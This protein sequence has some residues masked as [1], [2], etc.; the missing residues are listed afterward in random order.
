MIG[1]DE[2]ESRAVVDA[3]RGAVGQA[4]LDAGVNITGLLID[5]ESA[6]GVDFR[7]H[8]MCWQLTRV[9]RPSLT[10]KVPLSVV[11]RVSRKESAAPQPPEDM[12]WDHRECFT[13]A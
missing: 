1:S 5:I 3:V 11:R 2:A 7:Q 4:R 6:D 9:L 12:S 8:F 13:G 10:E